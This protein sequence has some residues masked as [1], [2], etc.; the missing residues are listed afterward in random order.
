MSRDEDASVQALIEA[1]V[2]PA[3]VTN[4][5]AQLERVLADRPRL[6]QTVDEP[7]GARVE[8]RIA[9]FLVR[10]IVDLKPAPPWT[11]P[12]PGVAL[13]SRRRCPRQALVEPE[14]R[15]PPHTAEEWQAERQ[16]YED[17]QAAGFPC[18]GCGK[19]WTGHSRCHCTACHES[20]SSVSAFDRHRIDFACRP[21]GDPGLV[22][23]DG[24]WQW[25]Q[26]EGAAL[27]W[28]DAAEAPPAA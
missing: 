23:V 24:Y 19:S 18:K 25:P 9:K 4:D 3:Q 6:V 12:A 1:H 15:T 11:P 28:Q 17:A 22:L 27:P 16:A 21:P 7:I 5:L 13:A 20:F 10:N 14:T 26:R 8:A 2:W